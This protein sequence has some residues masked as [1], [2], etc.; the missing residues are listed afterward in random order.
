MCFG[1]EIR[2]LKRAG[3]ACVCVR[4]GGVR[5]E[6]DVRWGKGGRVVMISSSRRRGRVADN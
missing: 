4:W 3:W 6:G 5:G 2:T 1:R